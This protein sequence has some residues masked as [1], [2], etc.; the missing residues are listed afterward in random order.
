[1]AE[2]QAQAETVKQQSE[3]NQLESAI[4]PEEGE[5]LEGGEAISEKDEPTSIVI[6]QLLG[7][8]FFILAPNWNMT[9]VEVE[10]LSLSYGAVIDKHFPDLFKELKGQTIE[11]AAITDTF[12]V[13]AP[14]IGTPR[15]LE[16]QTEKDVNEKT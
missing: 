2:D 12:E 15:K 4:E 3:F 14:R 10:R 5:V 6:S 8:T 16:Q 7:P 13:F 9:E 11:L 1:M